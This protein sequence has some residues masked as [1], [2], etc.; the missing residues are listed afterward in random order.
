MAS[1]L[2]CL[3]E[4]LDSKSFLELNA[5]DYIVRPTEKLAIRERKKPK[6][7]NTQYQTQKDIK[8]R[9]KLRAYWNENNQR[10]FRRYPK[11]QKQTNGWKT[12]NSITSL[13]KLQNTI[14]VTNW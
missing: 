4:C 9:K 12:K 11:Q 5:Q 13:P 14:V 7:L 2:L 10:E 6:T 1:V 3:K 8:I